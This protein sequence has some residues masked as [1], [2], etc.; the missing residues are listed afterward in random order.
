MLTGQ[1][2]TMPPFKIHPTPTPE[3]RGTRV[4][5]PGVS[6]ILDHAY[7]QGESVA[8]ATVEMTVPDRMVG[9]PNPHDVSGQKADHAQRPSYDEANP[10][11]EA[12]PVH[13]PFKF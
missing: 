4:H 13:R 1:V 9:D 12:K 7:E 10:Y 2:H 3:T 6:K 11:P 8:E 5:Q